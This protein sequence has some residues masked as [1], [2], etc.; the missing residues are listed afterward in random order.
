MNIPE[1]EGDGPIHR[2]SPESKLLA[3]FICS[4]L[5]FA[6]TSLAAL[7]W[8]AAAIFTLTLLCCRSAL[9]QWL[10]AW[11]LLVTIGS[12]CIWTAFARGPEAAL[13]TL[14]RLGSLSLFATMVTATTTVGQFIDTITRLAK[15]LEKLGIANARDIG[16]AIGLVIRF[17]PDV[18][19]RYR[20]VVDSHH[21]RGIR[22]RP[23]TII[24]PMIIATMLSADE[25]ADAIDARNIRIM[26]SK[27]S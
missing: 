8:L 11:P 4:L 14:L 21:A 18:H 19:Q 22:L 7:I 1:A 13:I 27:R 10:R 24:V 20:S 9:V 23:S 3:L 26:S 17:V 6:L 5:L 12:L 16:L 15:P 2:L 25:I